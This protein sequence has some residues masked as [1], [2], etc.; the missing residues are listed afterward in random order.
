[1]IGTAEGGWAL[2]GYL[3]NSDNRAGDLYHLTLDQNYCPIRGHLVDFGGWETA[4]GIAQTPDGGYVVTGYVSD[5]PENRR[6]SGVI[7]KTDNE[8]RE[9]W[10]RFTDNTDYSETYSAVVFPNG[11][12]AIGGTWLPG[13]GSHDDFAI[14]SIDAR[15]Q[16]QWMQHYGTPE[17]SEY[18][19]ALIRRA[20]EGLALAGQS[21]TFGEHGVDAGSVMLVLTDRFGAEQQVRTY[22][23]GRTIS[24]ALDLLQTEDL[25]FALWGAIGYSWP[26]SGITDW[27]A[28]LIKTDSTGQHEWSREYDL[29]RDEWGMGIALLPDGDFVLVGAIG[30]NEGWALDDADCFLIRTDDSGQVRWETAYGGGGHDFG[31]KVF[32]TDDGGYLIGGTTSSIG[33]GGTDFW[34][35]KTGRDPLDVTAPSPAHSAFF[36][37][38]PAFPNPFNSSTT[39]TYDIAKPGFVRLGVFDAGGRLVGTVKEGYSGSGKFSHSWNA[40][41]LTNGQYVVR[42]EYGEKTSD[43]RKLILMK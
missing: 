12:I 26:D 25:G 28:L 14:W 20:D 33:A 29:G 10:T 23:E 38:H 13:D 30:D 42:L 5:S 22:S 17:A 15:A 6:R 34:L 43:S 1:M 40:E 9:E 2:S 19:L 39:I 11:D 18:G 31:M 37:L 35:M 36:T 4:H 8:G 3:T 7:L 16:P 32:A 21:M 41:H 27:N 24:F